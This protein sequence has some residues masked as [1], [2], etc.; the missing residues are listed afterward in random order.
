[1]NKMITTIKQIHSKSICLF[2]IGSFYHVYGRDADIISYL[3]GYKIKMLE[4]NIKECGF[5]IS[6]ISRVVAQLEI[7]KIDYLKI[8]KRN[9]YE[10][11]EKVEYKNLNNYQK[12]YE[13]ANKYNNYK[14]R[15]NKINSFL[16]ENITSK[17]IS[18][19][20]GEIEK[21]INERGKV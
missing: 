13:K 6:I 18:E 11:E 8:N 7:S 17:T 21:I 14:E 4:P 2:E 20:L 10:V 9:N 5:P 19:I 3:F 16:M 15:V 12:V 1:M